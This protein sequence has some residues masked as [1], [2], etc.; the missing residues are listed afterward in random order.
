MKKSLVTM[1][2]LSATSLTST[3]YA[4][5]TKLRDNN[6][7]KLL[8][9][10]E[11]S[12][13]SV[14]D[15]SIVYNSSNATYYIVGSH[16]GL[17]K[18]TDLINWS[19][20]DNGKWVIAPA[21][22]DNY[23]DGSY[24]FNKPIWQ[25]FKSNPTHDVKLADGNTGTL[26]SF[27]A[28]AFCAIYDNKGDSAHI[29]G[30]M[31]APDVIYNKEMG[32]WCYYLSLNGDN[33]AS[34]IILMTGDSPVG[35]FT[36]QAP[37][38]FSGFNNQSYSGKKVNY[39]DTD[40][41]LVLGT[42][43]SLPARYNV[44]ESWGTYYPNCIDPNV[45][46]D[47]DG[48]LWLIYG[49]WSG[50]IYSLKLDKNTGLR[51]YTVSYGG[52]G[53]SPN[54]GD[55]AYFGK[56]IAGGYYVS[57]EGPYIRHIGDYYYL[58]MSYGGFAPGGY[59]E[60]GK[61]Q[62]GYDMRIFRSESPTGPFKDQNGISAI[63][64]SYQMNYGPTSATNR[65]HKIIGAYNDWANMWVGECAQGHNSAIVGADGEA[66]VV[67]HT[68]FNDGTY[69]HQVRIHRLFVNENGWLVCS[70][71]RYLGTQSVLTGS[72]AVQTTTQ[73][74]IETSQILTTQQLAGTYQLVIHPYKLDYKIFEEKV[75]TEV[76]LSEDGKISGAYTGTWAYS[77]EGKSYI[78][79]TI[80]GKTYYG[81][82][83]QQEINGVTGSDSKVH[84]GH[85]FANCITALCQSTGEPVWLY[86]LEEKSAI[87]YNFEKMT[88]YL[89]EAITTSAPN[90][91]YKIESSFTSSDE[92]VFTSEGKLI[93]P[94]ENKQLNLSI[95]LDG[96]KYYGELARFSLTIP[97]GADADITTGKIAHYAL[98]AVD[99]KNECNPSEQMTVGRASTSGTTPT[100]YD[101]PVRGNVLHQ[102]F[103]AI[104]AC[105]YTRM[106]N[107]LY[108]S[109]ADAFSVS[110]WVKP[111]NKTQYDAYFGFLNTTTVTNTT[112]G[113]FFFTD[114][115]YTGFNDMGGN[116][117]DINHPKNGTYK[118]LPA[119]Q[120][121]FVTM[122]MDKDGY[123]LYING[124]AQTNHA[125]EGSAT[126]S[127]FNYANAIS[128]ICGYQ[129]M[130]LGA[131]S[132]W[133]SSNA[134]LSDLSVYN[135]A[136]SAADINLL[137]SNSITPTGILDVQKAVEKQKT[138]SRKVVENGRIVIYIDG[139]CYNMQGQRI[140]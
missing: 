6:I 77:E 16:R 88:D 55:D 65:G 19:S 46:Y 127:T 91:L 66:Y 21:P 118:D 116:W 29:I 35:P 132:F 90:S 79:L 101:D 38:V 87:A 113:R 15:P 102:Y 12:A 106:N 30:N 125:Y 100:I 130:Y 60:K 41:E 93:P 122:T 72:L 80:A 108:T 86:T 57:G 98:N 134:Y 52:T 14:H 112:L 136:L 28:S 109:N 137:Y 131:G 44:G 81:V 56:K 128:K 33:W 119:T 54:T 51:D 129:Y 73:E 17:G 96:E 139:K 107:P 105:S 92:S 94:G 103:G 62:G 18:S 39:K 53:T 24:L 104:S 13:I 68:K 5:S 61:P 37:I 22:R 34:V 135:R 11:F 26:G 42:L 138:E 45:F 82:V 25:A 1:L 43:S 7:N 115:T 74:K 63:Y 126:V 110:F 3:M 120:W 99:N 85:L 70:P 84:G 31:W 95:R 140:K 75:P 64:N 67:F 123:T 78:T 36:Y 89:S 97:A 58:F 20:I 76:V 114:N 59:D 50:G 133:G 111:I 47:E 2:L 48:E 8:A 124:E 9:T 71:F 83:E 32:K 4:G 49:S 40:L 10:Q 23:Q 121:S 117:F 69:G 27:D